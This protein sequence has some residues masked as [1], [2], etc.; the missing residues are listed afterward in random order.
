MIQSTTLPHFYSYNINCHTKLAHSKL[1]L[2]YMWKPNTN[3]QQ[4]SK[5]DCLKHNH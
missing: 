5:F 4:T 1:G 2:K 3:N